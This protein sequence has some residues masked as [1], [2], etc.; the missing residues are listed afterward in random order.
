MVEATENGLSHVQA[1]LPNE[2]SAP[3]PCVTFCYRQ[4]PGVLEPH[5]SHALLLA[6]PRVLTYTAAEHD[7]HDRGVL[8]IYSSVVRIMN[9]NKYMFCKASD[10]ASDSS[11][12]PLL[13]FNVRRS[14]DVYRW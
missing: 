4:S 3:L 5:E 8:E 11:R 12:L 10:E 9:T 13:Y 6:V 2:H 7:L 1:L 14:N